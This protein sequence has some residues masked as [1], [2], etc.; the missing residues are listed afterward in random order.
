[1]CI[2]ICNM[3]DLVLR[4]IQKHPEAVNNFRNI[5]QNSLT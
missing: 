2:Y 5:P 3:M 4:N 1:M